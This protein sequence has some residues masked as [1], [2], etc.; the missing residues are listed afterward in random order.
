MAAEVPAKIMGINKGK[1]EAGCD[2]DVIVF[3]E[4]I[5]V[6]AAFVGGNQVV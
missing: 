4:G 2:A 3:D 6:K 5:N 1:L